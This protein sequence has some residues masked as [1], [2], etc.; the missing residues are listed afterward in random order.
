[1]SREIIE[2]PEIS[3]SKKVMML[4]D[5]WH[6]LW[7]CIHIICKVYNPKG[8]Y[9]QSALIC[10][11]ECL[12]DLIP[13][14]NACYSLNSFMKQNPIEKYLESNDKTFE[15]SYNLHNFLNIIKRR[16]GQKTYDISLR[17]AKEN[18]SH[19]TKKDWAHAVWFLIHFIAFNLPKKIERDIADSYKA[20]IVSLRYLIPCPECSNHMHEYLSEN[21]IEPFLIGNR[22]IFYWTWVFHNSVN[23]R[24]NK[25]CPNINSII[26]LYARN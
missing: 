23:K 5:D 11:F 16:K 9:A 8:E 10:F 14:E 22:E 1:M 17:E 7:Y 13:D 20:L 18:Y 25:P 6:Q 19:L 4:K 12:V 21:N 3:S 2:Y 24:I 26:H 15:W